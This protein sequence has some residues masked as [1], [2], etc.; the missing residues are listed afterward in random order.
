MA[1]QVKRGFE[2]GGWYVGKYKGSDEEEEASSP[3]PQIGR[4]HV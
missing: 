3:I 1:H 2:G 4:A